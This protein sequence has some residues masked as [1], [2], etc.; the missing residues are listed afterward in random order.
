MAFETGVNYLARR[1]DE[2]D[3][4]AFVAAVA[5]RADS[6][7][8]LDLHNVY[9]NAVNGRQTVDEFVAQLPLERVWEVHLAGGFWMDGYWLDAHSGPM[10]ASL[11]RSS[12][13]DRVPIAEPR[14]RSSSRSTRRSSS[15]RASTRSAGSSNCSGSCGRC[16][17]VMLTRE[18]RAGG[19]GLVAVERRPVTPAAWEMALGSLVIGRRPEHDL[20]IELSEDSGVALLQKL[21][22]EF[23][24]SMIAS[25]LRR[26]TR[27]MIL[28][29]GE[30]V[31]R[32][33]LA[34]YRNRVTPQM[35]AATEARAF[36]QF[37]QEL[38]V[39]VPQLAEVLE[40]ELAVLETL[41]DGRTRLVRF[42]FD[43]L[44][45]LL[46]LG[47]GRLPDE[48]GRSGLFEIEI[49]PDTARAIERSLS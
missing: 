3:D 48:P 32:M 45:M 4:G 41:L 49:T 31:F 28:A 43:P 16:G 19:T 9:T 11:F 30:N 2:M 39:S 25:N 12:E 42:E 46:A 37:I 36:A 38:G 29:L 47:D 24:A 13:G 22:L 44:P 20:G 10:P 18:L 6:G 40:F 23:R 33:I 8:L 34:E 5:E 21:A 7:I 14:V 35:F 1:P 26:T 17:V 27:L 15:P